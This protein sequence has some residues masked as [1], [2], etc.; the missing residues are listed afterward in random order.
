MEASGGRLPVISPSVWPKLSGHHWP[1]NVR[2]LENVIERGLALGSGSVLHEDDVVVGAER[3]SAAVS[4][5]AEDL[6]C[7]DALERRTILRALGQTKGDKLSAARLLGIGKT[8][9]YRK[10]KQYELQEP[11]FSTSP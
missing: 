5:Q 8:T 6:L 4:T 10:L 7:L 11:V 9:L 3:Q 1:G 2:E